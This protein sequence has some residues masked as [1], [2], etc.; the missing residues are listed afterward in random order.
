MQ[1]HDE[2]EIL[3]ETFLVSI[4]LLLGGNIKSQNAFFYYFQ[5]Q[6]KENDILKKLKH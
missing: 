4:T 6:D 2:I 5:N 1:E 3:E